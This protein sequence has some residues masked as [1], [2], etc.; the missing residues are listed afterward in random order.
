MIADLQREKCNTLAELLVR[1]P[2]DGTLRDDAVSS[3]ADGGQISAD[4]SPTL[5]DH[6]PVEDNHLSAQD[7]E[8]SHLATTNTI[9]GL[10]V[11]VRQLLPNPWTNR[12][13]IRKTVL[14]LLLL[15]L[16]LLMM[17][18]M[19]VMMIFAR[20]LLAFLPPF[21][22][23]APLAVVASAVMELQASVGG[24]SPWPMAA[25]GA[26]P[27]HETPRALGSVLLSRTTGAVAG[28]SS[29]GQ[30]CGTVLAVAGDRF[31]TL[32]LKLNDSARGVGNM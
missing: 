30:G 25:N 27:C 28:G 9:T 5:H 10:D 11:H 26:A 7:S 2:H 1:W 13:E 31:F 16:L 4:D 23:L 20:L 15:L 8:R 6:F 12:T 18:M 32:N 21:V 24:S 17:V 22:R 29:G 19:M 14:L 3:G